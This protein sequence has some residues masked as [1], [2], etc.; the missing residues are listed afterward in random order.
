MRE[1]D[2]LDFFNLLNNPEV[3]RYCFDVPTQEEIESRFSSRLKKWNLKSNH[4]LTFS[5]FRKED[6]KFVG[7]SGF[8]IVDSSFRAEVGYLF[9]PEYFG[10]GYATEAQ[11]FI[12]D[13]AFSIGISTLIANVTPG[14]LSSVR[15]LEKSGFEFE[16]ETENA[17]LINGVLYN[18]LLYIK[19][20]RAAA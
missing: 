7:I 14:N 2:K 20:L 18:N 9:L 4:W 6:G 11:Q 19:Y 16:A 13:Y 17:V 15:V 3:T 8:K 10:K 1:S 12:N 5:I